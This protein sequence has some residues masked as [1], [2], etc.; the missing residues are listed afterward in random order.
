M[1]EE[2]GGETYTMRMLVGTHGKSVRGLEATR[3]HAIFPD[4][5]SPAKNPELW[6]VDFFR[7]CNRVAE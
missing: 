3:F 2:V 5:Y 1:D 4:P 6:T 7:S